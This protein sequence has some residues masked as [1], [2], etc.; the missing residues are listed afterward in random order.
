ME[1]KE[2]LSSVLSVELIAYRNLSILKGKAVCFVQFWGNE[3]GIAFS[4]FC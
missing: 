1:A 4:G 3:M 2:E